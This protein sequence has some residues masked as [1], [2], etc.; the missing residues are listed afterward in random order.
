MKQKM[1]VRAGL[2]PESWAHKRGI[3]GID[4]PVL[5]AGRFIQAI[6]SYCLWEAPNIG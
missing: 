5:G 1:C 3:R 6:G 2:P 4:E